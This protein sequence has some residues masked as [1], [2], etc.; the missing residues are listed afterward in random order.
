MDL[1]RGPRKRGRSPHPPLQYWLS[2]RRVSRAALHALKLLSG[3]ALYP[4]YAEI[5]GSPSFKFF[6]GTNVQCCCVKYYFFITF[7]P[8]LGVVVVLGVSRVSRVSSKDENPSRKPK[9]EKSPIVMSLCIHF[10]SNLTLVGW[11]MASFYPI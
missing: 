6:G 10:V 7:Y 4:Q 1:I 9:D 8:P 11:P 5:H 2:R 3:A